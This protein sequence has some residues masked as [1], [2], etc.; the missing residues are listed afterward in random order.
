[1]AVQKD[2][3]II[4]NLLYSCVDKV[5]RG[6]EQFVP[7]H[8][9]GY[10]I[11][12]ETHI[13]SN[14]GITVL[15]AGTIGMVKRYQ[16]VKSVKIPPPDGEFKA[17]NIYFNQDILRNYSRER[18]IEASGRYP[19]EGYIF[20]DDPFIKG[21]FESLLPYFKHPS[22][23]S[24]ALTELKTKEAIELVLRIAPQLKDL[25]FD[26]TEPHKID[27]EEFMQ[28]NF[29]YNVPIEKFAQLTGRSL[30]SFKRDFEKIFS[31]SP[32]KWLQ[33]RRLSEAHYL[34][35]KKGKRS[36]DVY[37]EVGF[38]NLSHFSFAFKKE[39]GIAPSAL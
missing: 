27:L 9:L 20:P 5:Q 33:E 39:Y 4:N 36:S 31:Q 2:H 3:T 23:L 15:K 10:I 16:L 12:G 17:I 7:D 22:Q 32:G 14:N 34:I 18:N 29:M 25:L 35:S 38:E 6:N 30:A 1:M 21:F 8:S 11:S 13:T 19:G 28:K 24:N 26:F 37:I